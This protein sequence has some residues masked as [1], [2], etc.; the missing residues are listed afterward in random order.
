MPPIIR[1]AVALEMALAICQ[2]A[3]PWSQAVLP[4]G[5]SQLAQIGFL[6]GVGYAA[7]EL[8]KSVTDLTKPK[9]PR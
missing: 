2:A 7:S 5:G 6:F 9:K 3:V 8:W 4:L 1:A